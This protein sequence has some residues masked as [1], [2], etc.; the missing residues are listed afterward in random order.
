[1]RNFDDSEEEIKTFG[2]SPY[3]DIENFD[4][5]ALKGKFT[6]LSLNVQSIFAKFDALISTIE[7]LN[8]DDFQFSAICLQECWVHEGQNL[9]MMK[10]PNYQL[11]SRNRQCCGH[12]G[13][14]T[15]F[16]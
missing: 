8:N 14:V 16:H 11:I 13:L 10:I 1:M 4:R 9:S 3:I 7:Q 5:N 6:V 12:G 15:Y 2:Y